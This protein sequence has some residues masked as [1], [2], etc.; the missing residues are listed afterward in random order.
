[1]VDPRAP[2]LRCRAG[3]ASVQA[4]PRFRLNGS[5]SPLFSLCRNPLCWSG[6]LKCEMCH[7]ASYAP[8]CF[9]QDAVQC[10]PGAPN[11]VLPDLIPGVSKNKPKGTAQ[12]AISLL[13]LLWNF[14][15]SGALGCIGEMTYIGGKDIN[16]HG[17]LLRFKSTG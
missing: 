11:S 14:E 17:I 9:V 12:V 5:F 2:F 7:L 1:M 16:F 6:S 10:S 3:K 13:V 8:H 4:A 15:R